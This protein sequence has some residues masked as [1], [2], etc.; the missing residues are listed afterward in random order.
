[1]NQYIFAMCEYGDW[2]ALAIHD[3]ELKK[4]NPDTNVLQ[5]VKAPGVHY[6]VL[7]DVAC[8]DQ[9]NFGSALTPACSSLTRVMRK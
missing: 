3:G 4:Y 6:T 9:K 8:F 1:M 5:T 2:I 7:R